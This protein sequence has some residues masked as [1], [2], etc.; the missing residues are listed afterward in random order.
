MRVAVYASAGDIVHRR[1]VRFTGKME[2]G[3]YEV[4]VPGPGRRAHALILEHPDGKITPTSLGYAETLGIIVEAEA[5]APLTVDDDV[6]PLPDGK[7]AKSL[8]GDRL[9]VGVA[10]S[11]AAAGATG[12]MMLRW[13]GRT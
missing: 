3:A 13:A 6:S 5:G 11:P 8:P 12:R 1:W 4:T 7:L 9:C 10:I 2:R